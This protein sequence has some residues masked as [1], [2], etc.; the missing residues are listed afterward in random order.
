VNEYLQTS[1]PDIYAV[2]DCMENWDS[3]VGAKR[4]HQLALN[5]IRTGYIAGR[6]LI[7]NNSISYKGTVMPFVTELFGYQIGS[8]G[9][10][11]HEAKAKGIDVSSVSIETPSLRKRFGGKPAYYKI[12]AD[13]TIKTIIGVQIISEEM[14]S[15]TIDKLAVT[16]AAKMPLIEAVQVDSSYSP[17]VQEDQIA[18]PLQRLIDEVG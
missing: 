2:G 16:I 7:L 14:V 4:R 11:E 12:I 15:P 17:R 1:D 13:R 5:A 18:V 10:T 9:F 6:N 8:V 3:I